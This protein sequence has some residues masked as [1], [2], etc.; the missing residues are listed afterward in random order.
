M[1]KFSQF[2]QIRTH[3]L[4]VLLTNARKSTR[5]TPEECARLLGCTVEEYFAFEKGQRAPTLPELETLAY[6]FKVPL[7]HFWGKQIIQDTSAEDAVKIANLRLIRDRFLGAR[8]RLVRTTANLSL[9]E[10][11]EKSGIEEEDLKL[12]ESGRNPI[13][14]PVL[15]TL[16]K[17]LG[18]RVE[19][20]F[21]Q[22][23]PIGEW[24][25]EQQSI[26]RFLDLSP[27]L[28]DFVSHPVNVPYIEL[29]KRL[30]NLSVEKLRAIAEGILEITY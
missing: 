15:E 22:N 2:H 5:K 28:R 17:A 12:Y 6:F 30:S 14:L 8:L 23:G 26:Q 11:A 19:D 16:V 1:D 10:V 13:P 3:K 7:E 20:V 25:M 24:R 18:L 27:E 4:G 21:D 9:A 29:A